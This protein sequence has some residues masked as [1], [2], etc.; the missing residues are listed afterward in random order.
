[1][2]N[3]PYSSRP[4]IWLGDS[5]EALSSFPVAVKRVL[6]YGLRLVQNGE[7][8]AFAKPLR[9]LGAGVYELKA[10][11][12]GDAYRTVHL[13]KLSRAIYVIDAFQKKSRQG[14]KTPREIRDRLEGR[15]K[16]A[17]EM[18]EGRRA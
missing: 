1:M 6:G 5:R 14:S 3:L 7:T 2:A 11:I 12:R 17:R 18:D 10:D 9:G 16:R 13:V 4:L 15:I 8:P